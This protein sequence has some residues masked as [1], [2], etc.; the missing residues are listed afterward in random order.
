MKMQPT[1]DNIIVELG[2]ATL[3]IPPRAIAKA[4]LERVIA[5]AVLATN[6][7]PKIGDPWPSQGGI[8]A[9]IARGYSGEADA[10][11]IVGP[12]AEKA[13]KWQEAVDWA[14]NQGTPAHADFRLPTRK[15]QA[16]C[17]ANV[18]E[19]FENNWYWSGE[20]F[21]G[22]DGYAWCQYFGDGGQGT[23]PKGTDCRARAVR[24]LP[25]Q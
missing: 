15:E 8:Y 3:S 14:K 22:D 1:N 21:A 5:G 7:V 2:G 9:G 11:L 6:G 25:I 4:L 19:L 20:Q 24:R 10:Y 18:P 12:Q 13:L 23:G 17:F 16:L